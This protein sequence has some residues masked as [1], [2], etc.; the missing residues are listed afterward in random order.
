[1]ASFAKFGQPIAN[2]FLASVHYLLLRNPNENLARYYPSITKR[3]SEEIPFELFK[4]FCLTHENRIKDALSTKIVQTN[5]INRCSYLMPIFS[6]IIAREN[7]S[8]T[9]IDIGTSAGLTLNFDRYE[10]WYNGHKMY[11]N[12]E[13][14]I[15]SNIISDTT[16]DIVKIEQPLTKIGIDQHIIDPTDPEEI[17][18]LKALIWPDQLDRYKAM[19]EALQLNE[20]KKINYV[21]ASSIRDFENQ[22]LEMDQVQNLIIYA[23]HVLYQFPEVEKDNF[24]EMLERIGKKRDYYF[25][26]VEGTKALLDRNNSNETVIELTRYKDAHKSRIFVAETNGHGN[27]IKWKNPLFISSHIPNPT[28]NT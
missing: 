22:I 8:T 24:C 13:V 5:V 15:K 21:Q 16:C 10:Y 1:M 27:W 9:L 20:L 3:Q 2:L 12:S 7:K 6:Q 14:I 18:W 11:G 25:L 28:T 23:T 26:S 4:N 19:E 17:L